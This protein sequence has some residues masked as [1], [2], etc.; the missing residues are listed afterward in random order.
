M[1]LGER[2]HALPQQ[3]SGREPTRAGLAVAPANTPA[4]LL[5]DEPTGEQDGETKRV[6][7]AMLRDRAALGCAVLIVT[8][9]AE[10]VRAERRP[11]DH[12][13]GRQGHRRPGPGG[14]SPAARSAPWQRMR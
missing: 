9:S 11:G 8:H 1:R 3:L 4:V 2:M 10:V 13:G 5:A 6:V 12:A 14:P 7:F